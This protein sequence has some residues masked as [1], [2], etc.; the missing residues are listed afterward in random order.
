MRI[1]ICFLTTCALLGISCAEHPQLP[2][3]VRW[4]GKSGTFAWGSGEVTLPSGFTYQVDQGA[5]TFE[6]H[7]TSPDGKTV[8][9]YDIGWY[10]GAWATREKAFFFDARV[11][12]G[13]RVWT[14]KRDWPDGKG[15][16]T[17]LVAVTF[18]DSGCA[19]FFLA[20]ARVE[21]ATFMHFIARSFRP[22]RRTES[23]SPCQ[24]LAPSKGQ[25]S[26]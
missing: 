10:A 9:G 24:G 18:P 3:G 4:S 7:F 21:D 1:A 15:G 26:P 11:V 8:V 23:S 12:D 22:K 14:A 17:T 19:N 2:S 13:A 16:R 25:G 5:D 20:S 6:G